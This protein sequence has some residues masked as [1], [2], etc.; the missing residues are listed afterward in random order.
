[1]FRVAFTARPEGRWAGRK[2]A[3]RKSAMRRLI[4]ERGKDVVVNVARSTASI[5]RSI[6]Y[7]ARR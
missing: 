1:M 5:R 4:D 3:V 6:G 7:A 2:A